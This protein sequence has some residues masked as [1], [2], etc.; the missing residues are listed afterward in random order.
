VFKVLARAI[1]QLEEIKRKQNQKKEVKVGFLP[2][3][4]ADMIVYQH[5]S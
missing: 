4:A 1:R 3:F 5:P 2:S